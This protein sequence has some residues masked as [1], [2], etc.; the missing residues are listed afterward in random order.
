MRKQ[1]CFILVLSLFFFSGTQQKKVE[2][3]KEDGVEVVV[4]RLKPYKV[5]G[6]PSN[7]YLDEKFRI[8]T[9]RDEFA[10]IGFTDIYGFDVDSKG[11][12]YCCVDHPPDYILYKFDNNGRFV[13]GFIKVGQGP[14]EVTNFTGTDININDE[15]E[16]HQSRGGR[17]YFYDKDGNFIREKVHD[18]LALFNRMIPME[19]GNY[20]VFWQEGNYSSGFI[21]YIGLYNSE[22]EERKTLDS[23]EVPGF[24]SEKIRAVQFS[25]RWA[26]SKKNIFLGNDKRG[27]EIWVFD[28]EG[29]LLRKIKK[30]H[31]PFNP[32]IVSF[33]TGAT[34]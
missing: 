11:N 28:L 3:Y 14:G 18:S 33:F 22:F 34:Y 16:I 32:S 12:I 1:I 17:I 15:I 8:D 19:N 24:S 23:I 13:K 7:L 26:V 5:K 25:L 21:K 27:Y 20:L 31:I 29:N 2:K 6:G 9:E 30:K 10:E 4:N